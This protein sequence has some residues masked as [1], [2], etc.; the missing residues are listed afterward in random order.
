MI[1]INRTPDWSINFCF[2][3][4]NLNLVMRD[5]VTEKFQCS[6]WW[7]TCMFN[8]SQWFACLENVRWFIADEHV[9]FEITTCSYRT[10]SIQFIMRGN[11]RLM[12]SLIHVKL[13]DIVVFPYY[14]IKIR[15]RHYPWHFSFIQKYHILYFTGKVN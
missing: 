9:V 10:I 14:Q 5:D 11:V 3:S 15:V 7:M 13:V 1:A 2:D 12:E 6:C 4:F 8:M